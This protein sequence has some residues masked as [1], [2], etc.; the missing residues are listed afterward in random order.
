MASGFINL[1]VG[2]HQLGKCITLSAAHRGSEWHKAA[3][4]N[5]A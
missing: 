5:N 1:P 3:T 2:D 4:F